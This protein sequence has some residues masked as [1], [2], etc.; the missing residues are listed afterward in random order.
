M[1]SRS[2]KSLAHSREFGELLHGEVV[3]ERRRPHRRVARVR[4]LLG[5]GFDTA[6]SARVLACVPLAAAGPS[7]SA[8]PVGPR[9]QAVRRLRPHRPH[10][11]SASGLTFPLTST[12]PKRPA[13]RERT[14]R[15]ALPS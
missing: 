2:L 11:G 10:A 4:G 13:P 5:A 9:R 12:L 7:V 8:G 3:A 1:L 6:E 15:R 14:G